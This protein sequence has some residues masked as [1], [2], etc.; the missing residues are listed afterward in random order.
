MPANKNDWHKSMQFYHFKPLTRWINLLAS[1][2]ILTMFSITARASALPA[3]PD[4]ITLFTINEFDND[5]TALQLST[6]VPSQ[7]WVRAWFKWANAPN[8]NGLGYMVKL[9]HQHGALFG[10]GV[11]C[12]A[13]Y[14][15]ENGISTAQ[16]MNMATRDPYGR[17][18]KVANSWYH[19]SLE[20][21]AYRR[22]VLKWAEQ[23]IDAGVD[24]LF[25]D[26]VNGAYSTHEGFDPY[27]LVAFRAYLIRRY[28]QGLH[29][30]VTDPRWASRFRI[31]FNDANECPDHTMRTF[32]YAAYLRKNGWADDPNQGANPLAP[33]WGEPNAITGNSYSADRNNEV[34]HDWITHIRAYAKAHHRRVWIAANGLNR[35]VDYQIMGCPWNMPFDTHNHFKC[36][37][38]N[39]PYWRAA[40]ERSQEL[41]DG[42]DVPIMTFHD[43]G[44]GMPWMNLTSAERVAWLNAY[45]PEVFAAGL[46]F[47]YPVHGPFGCDAA[48][49]GTLNTIQKQARFVLSIAPLLHHVVWQ[50][51][52]AARFSGTAETVI[53][54]QPAQ[55]HLIIHLINRDYDGLNPVQQTSR[56]LE[57]AL[58]VRPI[59][60]TIH[61][62]DTGK[63]VSA[64][65]S[66]S[67][68]NPLNGHRNGGTLTVNIPS[69]L[70]WDVV[71]IN[72]REWR[73]L[74]YPTDITVSCVQLW[75]RPTQN[76]FQ[77]S[78]QNADNLYGLNG[79]I[80]GRL[81]PDLRNNPT[82]VVKYRKAG[83]FEVH[84][85]SVAILG[86][87]LIIRVDG[88]PSLT[89]PIADR[90]GKNDG[91]A[92]EINTTYS[93]PIPPGHHRI[94]VD[95]NGGDWFTVDWYR[96]IGL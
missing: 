56:R 24:T 38:T 60:V 86:A 1:L 30:T 23:Q 72:L 21:P 65:W 29:W 61:N 80:Q 50:D 70:T 52:T 90:D 19:G 42:R 64:K 32:D 49:D 41:M 35:W 51:Q 84:V 18:Y 37:G 74:P 17:L 79:I 43:W 5:S 81:H 40:Y 33:M 4:D 14:P 69:L 76:L 22:Y 85:N 94:S 54:G 88:K 62:A 75:Q 26:E 53:E 73:H 28:V 63:M 3:K 55:R 89:M 78:P 15:H 46:F 27:G 11:T 8:L 57:V 92:E 93:V 67:A 9:A 58:A 91:N 59:S 2:L 20:N 45:A 48:T 25:M 96:F 10:G 66:Y 12:S 71:R 82:F 39:L 34:W 87:R 68:S 44:V 36:T 77:V 6:E 95:N 7:D 31:D 83:R 16:F 13:L 47:A